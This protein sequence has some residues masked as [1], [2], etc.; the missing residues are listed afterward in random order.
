MLNDG[1]VTL[2]TLE[3]YLANFFEEINS[4]VSY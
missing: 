3:T 1:L 2:V 4:N